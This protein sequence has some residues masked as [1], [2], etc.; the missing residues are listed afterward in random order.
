[1]F[2]ELNSASALL[3]CAARPEGAQVAPGLTVAFSAPN[4][5]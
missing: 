4:P 5:F 3:S 2:E 1:M